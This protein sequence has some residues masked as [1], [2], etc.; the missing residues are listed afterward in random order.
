MN[1]GRPFPTNSK[2]SRK[3]HDALDVL[4]FDQF[5]N[6]VIQTMLDI[7][8]EAK[9]KKRV[10]NDSWF[11]RLAERI[12]KSQHKLIRYSSGKKILEKLSA[13]VSD[14]KDIIQDENFDPALKSLIVP[15]KFR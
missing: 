8:V 6:Y 10:G 9:E 15:K 11:K 7:A 13:A 4:L 12:I 3:G 1:L 5:G 14:D 2:I